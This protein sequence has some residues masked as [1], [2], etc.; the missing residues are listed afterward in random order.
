MKKIMIAACAIALAAVS[1]A[2]SVTWSSGSLTE[3]NI[4]GTAADFA[5]C[6]QMIVFE[7]SAAYNMA[8][9]YSDYKAG[10][11]AGTQVGTAT[12]DMMADI[13]GEVTVE[14][15][16]SWKEGNSVYG[17][18]LF[19]YSSTGDFDK[20]EYYMANTA[21]GTAADAGGAVFDLG[22]TV[23]GLGGSTATAWTAVPEPTS[24]LLMLV[25]L[26]GLALR[27]RRA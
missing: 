6:V 14:G 2:A 9:I 23:G 5:D 8:N 15:G 3:L 20:A 16:T 26:A 11:I 22:N 13:F 27:R 17:A 12:W 4:D 18:V 21:V 10:K 25:G 7:N 1:Q 19:L 24:G